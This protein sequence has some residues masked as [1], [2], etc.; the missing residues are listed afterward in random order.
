[1]KIDNQTLILLDF[2]GTI[3]KTDRFNWEC[4]NIVLKKYKKEIKIC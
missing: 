2:D 1:M 3:L 4:Y